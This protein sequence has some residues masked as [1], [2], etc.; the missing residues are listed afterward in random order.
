[1]TPARMGQ[2]SDLDPPRPKRPWHRCRWRHG[3]SRAP[4][5]DD[6]RRDHLTPVRPVLTLHNYIDN[7]A[8]AE[9]LVVDAVSAQIG[10]PWDRGLPRTSAMLPQQSGRLPALIGQPS[11][12]SYPQDIGCRE[13]GPSRSARGRS[14]GACTARNCSALSRPSWDS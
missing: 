1:M 2:D 3:V 11:P 14:P 9:E 7:R 4:S 13:P 8:A 12:G 10:L 5:D 6:V